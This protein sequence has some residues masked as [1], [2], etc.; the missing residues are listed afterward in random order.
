M[1]LKKLLYLFAASLFAL[2]LIDRV[3]VSPTLM[4]GN[5]NVGIGVILP[6]LFLFLTFYF[7]L[8]VACYR[9]FGRL[10]KGML[11]GCLPLL[12]LLLAGCLWWETQIAHHLLTALGGG[13]EEP[14]SRIYRF[15]WFNQY[16][17]TLFFNVATFAATGLLVAFASAAGAWKQGRL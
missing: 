12:L 13:P 7:Y 17:N 6:S 8:A 15:G 14:Q 10:K 5:G 9:W 11:L 4:S 16:T 3:T 1:E 2:F